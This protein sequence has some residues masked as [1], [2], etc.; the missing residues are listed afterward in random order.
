MQ[1]RY[2]GR[3]RLFTNKKEFWI[4]YDVEDYGVS[5]QD[6]M[7]YLTGMSSQVNILILDACRDNRKVIGIEQDH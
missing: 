7:R 1:D 2:T 5:V 6:I 4:R 3:A